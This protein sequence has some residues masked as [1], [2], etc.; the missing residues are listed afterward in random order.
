MDTL[1]QIQERLVNL[2][3]VRDAW[4]SDVKVRGD[5]V[6]LARRYVDGDHDGNMTAEMRAALRVSGDSELN[7]NYMDLV[8]SAMADRLR[9]KGIDAVTPVMLERGQPNPAQDWVNSVLD[10]NRFDGLQMF[11][12]RSTL[13]DGDSYVLVDWDNASKRVRMTHELAYDGSEGMTVIH[14]RSDRRKVAAAVKVWSL[15][16]KAYADTIRVNVYFDDRIE[17]YV[18]NGGT[19]SIYEDPNDPPE[20]RTPEGYVRWTMMDGTPIGVPVVQF[21]NQQRGMTGF[22]I[23]RIENAIPLQNILNRVVHSTVMTQEL[24]GFPIRM[25][26]GVAAPKALTPGMFIDAVTKDTDGKAIPPTPAMVEWLK[27]IRAEQLEAAPVDGFLAHKQSTIH[28]IAV[29]TCT[30]DPGMLSDDASGESRKQAEVGLLAKI[31]AFQVTT[32][33]AYEDT[34]K[35]AHRIQTAYGLDKPP[36]IE[37]FNCQWQG[38]QIRNDKE[39]AEIVQIMRDDVP[40]EDRLRAVGGVFGYSEERIQEITEQAREKE[41]ADLDRMLMTGAN[42]FGNFSPFGGEQ[43]QA[44]GNGANTLQPE[45]SLQGAN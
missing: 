9:V 32:G 2:Q 27:A 39:V 13:E 17:K 44:L 16:G 36:E 38:A 33:N 5:K 41:Q 8:V 40:L 6:A 30:P 24:T 18:S 12:H 29:I 4:S 31:H 35:L 7:I 15:T 19:L 22:G 11:L 45:T 25:L 34:I 21:S 26:V 3:I 37:T 23:S 10:V 28:D 14:E 20:L 43:N 42:S 1:S